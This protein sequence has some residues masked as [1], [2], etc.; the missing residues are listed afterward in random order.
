MQ[1]AR[2][3]NEGFAEFDRSDRFR[4]VDVTHWVSRDRLSPR[5]VRVSRRAGQAWDFDRG[6]WLHGFWCYDWSDEALKAASYDPASGELRLAVKHAYGIGSPRRKDS[7]HAFYAL[8]VFEELDHPA[9]T[10]WIGST[11]ACTSGR[12]EM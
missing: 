6:V 10:T 8:H 5:L 1:S 7:K 9:S 11:I 2:W 4:R 3:P 12:P